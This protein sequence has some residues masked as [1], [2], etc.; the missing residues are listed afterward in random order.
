MTSDNPNI[1]L[2]DRLAVNAQKSKIWTTMVMNS[3]EGIVQ[4][5]SSIFFANIIQRNIPG[6]KVRGQTCA[7]CSNRATDRCHGIGESRPDLMRRAL[8]RIYPDTTKPICLK[9]IVVAFLE[10]HKNTKLSF[11]CNACHLKEN[12]APQT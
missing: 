11:K 12:N 3:H 8:A 5:F 2:F 1:V 10:E 4:D 9:D 6:Y 7:D